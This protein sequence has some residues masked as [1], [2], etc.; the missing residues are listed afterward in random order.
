M[1][2]ELETKLNNKGT[3][4]PQNLYYSVR[5]GNCPGFKQLCKGETCLVAEIVTAVLEGYTWFLP[6]VSF[7]GSDVYY[8]A[9]QG[10]GNVVLIP[11]CEK[12]SLGYL[13]RQAGCRGKW[14][15]RDWLLC[16]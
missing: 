10:N 8:T 13:G 12:W 14:R 9:E 15:S 4:C 2:S 11:G 1:D 16:V 7:S 6:Y 3:C 5:F